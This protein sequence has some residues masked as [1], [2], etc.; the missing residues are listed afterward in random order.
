MG[1]VNSV[2]NP[3]FFRCQKAFIVHLSGVGSFAGGRLNMAVDGR[4]ISVSR[5]QASLLRQA[6]KEW[7]EEETLCTS[8]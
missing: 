3:P 1:C 5:Q 7:R 2:A 4:R 6:L 8:R